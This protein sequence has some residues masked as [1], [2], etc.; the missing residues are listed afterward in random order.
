MSGEII[1]VGTGASTTEDLSTFLGMEVEKDG[2][3]Y[4]LIQVHASGTALK[5][6]AAAYVYATGTDH[7]VTAVNTTTTNLNLFVGVATCAIAAGSYGWVIIKGLATVFNQDASSATTQPTGSAV[8]GGSASECVTW[9]D[10]FQAASSASVCAGMRIIGEIATGSV[11][12]TSVPRTFVAR[13][14]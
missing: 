5:A 2:I 12:S 1:P 7:V 9:D 11:S 3:G 6:Y 4:R 8:Y 10:V 14:F 13:L